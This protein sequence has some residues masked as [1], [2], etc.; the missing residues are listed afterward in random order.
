MINQEDLSF[1]I[2]CIGQ[3]Y[4]IQKDMDLYGRDYTE[5]LFFS[6]ECVLCPANTEEISRLMAYCFEREIPV[7]TRGAGTGLSGG[8]L[9]VN[10]GVVMSMSRFNRILHIDRDNL[11]V[12]VQPGVINQILKTAVE[13]VGLY[14]P[15]DPASMG[16]CFLGGNIAHGSGGPRA[17]K[18]GTTKDYVLDLEVVRA[19]GHVFHTGAPVLK[20]STGYNLTQLIVGS[21]GTLGI[22][23]EITFRLIPYPPHRF[24]FLA[25][26]EDAVSCAA[27]VSALFQSGF[28]P[29]CCEFMTPDAWDLGCQYTGYSMPIPKG[30]AYLL[31]EHDGMEYDQTQEIGMRM[32]EHLLLAGAVDVLIPDSA[33]K[34]EMIWKIRRSI[35][36]AAKQGNVYKEEDT[37][38]P[39]AQLPAVLK[40]V[41]ELQDIFHFRTI[42]YG[43]AGDGNLHINI[44]KDLLSDEHWEHEIPKA[45]RLLFEEVV[46]LGGTISGEHGIGYV[47]R[48]YLPIAI[49]QEEIILM[50]AIKRVF[51]PKG[52]LNPGKIFPSTTD[53]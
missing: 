18:Y 13:E 1:F 45:I 16:S 44:L 40:K 5:D 2:Q 53:S 46:R 14:Y 27:S 29:S 7:T 9:P 35:G 28:T 39:R 8:A 48:D 50:K 20:N 43:H 49:K 41:K 10:G 23:T 37:V 11:Q 21:E 38:V 42:I 34:T 24:I 25:I 31:V 22:I 19:D 30:G 52:I 33:E 12:C 32:A 3:D 17:V 36:E 26:F 6:P 51:D 4:V 15:P 47:Q